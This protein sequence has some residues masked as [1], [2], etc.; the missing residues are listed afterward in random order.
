MHC[1][2]SR[3]IARGLC[4]GALSG[5]FAAPERPDAAAAAPRLLARDA[6]GKAANLTR[7]P[8][9]PVLSLESSSLAPDA[10]AW[11]FTGTL[12]A[13]LQKDL[14]RLPLTAASMQRLVRARTTRRANGLELEPL[15]TLRRGA[16][17]TFA[18]PHG[19]LGMS[20]AAWTAALQID[21]DPSAGA[22]V[23]GT[24]PAP[25]AS[26]VPCGMSA[27]W[28]SFDGL[29]A[30]YDAG[31]WLQD[32][33][34]L[35]LETSLLEVPCDDVDTAA[36]SCIQLVP[37]APLEPGEHHALMSGRALRDAHGAEV[38]P[39]ASGFTTAPAAGPAPDLPQLDCARDELP[40]PGGCALAFDDFVELRLAADGGG[41]RLRVSI[42]G[43]RLARLPMR[44]AEPL[45]F[46]ELLPDH[47]Y[48]LNLERIDAIGGSD[49]HTITL[50]TAPPLA[51]LSISEVRADPEGREPDQEYVELF[52][53]GSQAVSLRGIALAD[54]PDD[55]GMTLARDVLLPPGARA[56]LVADAFSTDSA[57]D[58]PPAIGTQL[59]RLGKTLTHGGLSNS[60]ETL[61]LR[62][63]DGR[64]L[65]AA[66]PSPPPRP[67][68]CIART[69]DDP[70][71][72]DDGSFAYDP[73]GTCT[74]GS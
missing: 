68:L 15:T 64:R 56:L 37:H 32:Q 60:G 46:D 25:G 8:R 61:Y 66:P 69:S 13:A 17:Y 29:V 12:D 10:M 67:G 54:G 44:S 35:A 72:G 28:L 38:E 26:A 22:L 6:T 1:F 19:A 59:L 50:R 21:D 49:A 52:N 70:R 34:G 4:F 65:S 31:V 16:S 5:C 36:A 24:F 45:R 43:R 39:I 63:A 9:R 14:E 47:E 53:F 23:R 3:C 55:P 11:L 51:T 30:G 27:A 48:A 57:L 73:N 18:L 71:T 20:S 42:D 2:V 40:I 62:D 33:A 41:A 74:P 7:L 58:T